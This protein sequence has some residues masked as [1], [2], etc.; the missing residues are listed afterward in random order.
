ML[1]YSINLIWSEEDYC[2]VARVSEF[3]GLSAF[4]ETPEEAVKEVKIALDGFIKVYEEDGCSI[5]EPETLKQY[6]GQTRLRLPKSLHAALSEEAKIEGSSLNSFIVHLLSEKHILKKVENEFVELK[7]YVFLKSFPLNYKE[8]RSTS[9]VNTYSI[10][11]NLWSIT[12]KEGR[13][14]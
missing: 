7:E 12:K 4:G 5:P 9:D 6:S 11:S 1:K 13:T 3:P 8:R 2:Y 10:I 14:Q